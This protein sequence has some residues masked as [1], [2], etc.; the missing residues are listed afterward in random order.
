[1]SAPV[2]PREIRDALSVCRKPTEIK[3]GGKHYK[4]YVGG[5][6]VGVVTHNTRRKE[7]RGEGPYL[8]VLRAIQ[9]EDCAP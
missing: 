1:M 9:R 3:P 2:F 5:K 4:I 8:N 6:M 7:G